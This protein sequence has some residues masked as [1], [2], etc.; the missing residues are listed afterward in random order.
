MQRV[1]KRVG[2]AVLQIGACLSLTASAALENSQGAAAPTSAAASAAR[3]G[4]DG[5]TPEAGGAV[6]PRSRCSGCC[7]AADNTSLR[8]CKA[9]CRTDRR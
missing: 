6:P 1:A 9:C 4:S 2:M 8:P 7:K 3:R 5:A